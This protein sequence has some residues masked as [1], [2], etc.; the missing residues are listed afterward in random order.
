MSANDF[1]VVV[2]VGRYEQDEQW[3]LKGPCANACAITE[4]LLSIEVPP[5]QVFLFIDVAPDDK[6]HFAPVLARFA[7]DGVQ[8]TCSAVWPELDDFFYGKLGKNRPPH[9]RLFL[10]WS[11]H[12]FARE[13]DGARIFV[14][15]DYT[16]NAKTNRVVNAT[17][18]LRYLRSAAFD[19]FRDQLIVADACASYGRLTFDDNRGFPDDVGPRNQLAL[20]AT[21]EGAYAHE[22]EGRGVFTTIVLTALRAMKGWPDHAKL[23]LL[24]EEATTRDG[25]EPFRL[26]VSDDG[27]EFVDRL[28]GSAPEDGRTGLSRSVLGALS[29]ADVPDIVFRRHYL[30]VVN[31]LGEPALA[32]AQTLP[33][34]IAE[35]ASLQDGVHTGTVPH[36]LLQFLLRLERDDRLATIVQA[37]LASQAV[38]QSNTVATIRQRLAVENETKIL[39]LELECD[40]AGTIAAFD[41]FLRTRDLSAVGVDLLTRQVVSGWDDFRNKLVRTVE[42]VAN[43]APDFEVHILADPP[44]FDRPFHQIPLPSGLALGEERVV[45]LRHRQ[46]VRKPGAVVRD[47]WFT[48]AKALRAMKPTDIPLVAIEGPVRA[49]GSLPIPSQGLCYVR[50]ALRAA[51]AGHNTL[52]AEKQLLLR[53]LRLGVPY[54]YWPHEL[55]A[56]ASWDAIETDIRKW[57]DEAPSLETI[58]QQ[59]TRQRTAGA[60]TATGGT[61]LWDDP[62][63]NPFVT[64]FGV[65][66]Q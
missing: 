13:T 52:V 2:G 26:S 19:C 17:R 32:V 25:L 35:L 24:I 63:F 42:H 36:G 30:R 6:A 66:R 8:V 34:M 10:F 37:W 49:S 1:A 65:E 28:V 31:D 5:A 38:T 9:A 57:L 41:S 39:F 40:Q 27:T 56:A 12:G 16:A 44:V 48:H 43:T 58:P 45:V 50:F 53:L 18:V 59:L 23:K 55:A 15:A 21:T 46:R 51:A 3:N 60:P 33:E 4:W 7:A 14:C 54:L 22:E 20:F 64:T 61:L 29:G 62:E 11:G 47:A